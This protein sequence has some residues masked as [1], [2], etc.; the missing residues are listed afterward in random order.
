MST[1]IELIVQA[2]VRLKNRRALD[3]MLLHRQRLSVHLHGRSSDF[4]VSGPLHQVE[5]DIAVIQAGVA[6]LGG[7]APVPAVNWS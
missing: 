3:D 1:A 5:A 6:E 7:T 2:Y 4:D